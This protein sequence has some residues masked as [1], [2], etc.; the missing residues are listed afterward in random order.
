M[1]AEGELVVF[2]FWMV[3]SYTRHVVHIVWFFVLSILKKANDGSRDSREATLHVQVKRELGSGVGATVATAVQCVHVQLF[4]RC[5][6]SL[7]IVQPPCSI[8]LF[9]HLFLAVLNI[10]T[11]KYQNQLLS[12]FSIKRL[13]PKYHV[14]KPISIHHQKP[15]S[16]SG[17]F[18]PRSPNSTPS[19]LTPWSI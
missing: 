19:V 2:H 9:Y 7:F 6:V 14:T 3:L 11:R 15:S 16:K 8:T 1:G 10:L 18:A 13:A 17:T 12:H 4:L 5:V